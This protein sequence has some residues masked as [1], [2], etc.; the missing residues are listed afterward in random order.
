[1][2]E[3]YRVIRRCY[4]PLFNIRVTRG[5]NKITISPSGCHERWDKYGY[6]SA[7]D[8][9][10]KPTVSY[11]SRSIYGLSAIAIR[12][13][14]NL[15]W[16]TADSA[17]RPG[18]LLTRDPRT[19]HYRD[20]APHLRFRLERNNDQS[21]DLFF[22]RNFGKLEYDFRYESFQEFLCNYDRERTT[23]W[24]VFWWKPSDLERFLPWL[25]P[26]DTFVHTRG[27]KGK[28]ENERGLCDKRVIVQAERRLR[29][30]G[31][32]KDNLTIHDVKWL[33]LFCATCTY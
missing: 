26:S 24:K 13:A 18:L 15:L 22:F 19:V 25:E 10:N 16:I 29:R 31:R 1:M 4:R 7:A 27:A 5:V 32:E 23:K 12:S 30:V 17:T 3:R 8:N 9:A 21:N 33:Q 20:L 6:L 2:Y 28:K 11:A 14:L